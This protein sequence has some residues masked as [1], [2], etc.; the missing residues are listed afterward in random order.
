VR[1]VS[2]G[3]QRVSEPQDEQRRVLFLCRHPGRA[4]SG[5]SA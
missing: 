5:I 2:R 1:G 3:V 4:Y